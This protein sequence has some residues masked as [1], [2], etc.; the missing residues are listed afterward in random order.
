MRNARH[1]TLIGI[2]LACPQVYAQADPAAEIAAIR[3]E[4]ARLAER[5]D[6]LE[7]AQGGAVRD[8]AEAPA[9][10][11][12]AAAAP[13]AE[14]DFPV[15]NLT[16]DL[17][18]RHESI[19]E[20][21]VGERH[22]HRIRARL[23]LAAEVNE[24]IEVGLGLTSGDDDPVSA[25]QTLDGGFDRNP[26]GIDRAFFAWQATDDLTFTGGKMATPFFRPGNHH[27]I[28][29]SDLNPEG[30]AA[31]YAADN[32][33]ANYAGL[34]VEERSAANDSI[35]LGGQVGLRREF[36][37]GVRLTAG[38]SYYDYLETQGYTPFFDGTAAGNRLDAGG[39]YLNDFNE[40]EVFAQ[41]DFSAGG[42]RMTVFADYVTN[43]EADDADLGYAIGASYGAVTSP[44][45]W[46]LGY[47]YQSLEADAVIGTFTDSDFGGGGTD[48]KGHVVD[49][50][51]GLR[52]RWLLGF[53]YFLN[54]RGADVGNEHDYNRLQA[55]VVFT[56]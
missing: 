30:L 4:I 46:R 53:R 25:N 48:N 23:A 14:P 18:Y 32:W 39:A 33:F 11:V 2:L 55:D 56:Y 40:A 35:L 10:A 29:D 28:F 37:D 45:T 6:K 22:R 36:D 1:L 44:G 21:T 8:A 19:N 54:E 9:A 38:I 24:R 41:L 49:F 12:V 34:W 42:R 47:A 26:L 52:D 27:L 16:G 7:Q 5:L 20:D 15:L 43:T 13:A 17:R 31:S 3:G 50:T 51:Y